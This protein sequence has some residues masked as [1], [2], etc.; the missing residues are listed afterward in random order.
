[1]NY[2]LVFWFHRKEHKVE[3]N[4]VFVNN[5]LNMKWMW[6]SST[7]P[8]VLLYLPFFQGSIP[9]LLNHWVMCMIGNYSPEI[10]PCMIYAV[11]IWW[12]CWPIHFSDPMFYQ[13]PLH[14]MSKMR[15]SCRVNPSPTVSAKPL[16]VDWR[17]LFSYSAAVMFPLLKPMAR[18]GQTWHLPKTKLNHQTVGDVRQSFKDDFAPLFVSIHE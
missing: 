18:D 9:E 1:M 6:W 16:T 13:I 12:A 3:R 7:N 4:I 2:N 14:T 10:A 15:P 5:G 17:I 8:E 11:H